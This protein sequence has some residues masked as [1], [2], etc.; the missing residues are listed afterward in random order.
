L[1][2]DLVLNNVVE[3]LKVKLS[4]AGPQ[5]FPIWSPRVMKRDLK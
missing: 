3:V 5:K 2:A 1:A 4:S